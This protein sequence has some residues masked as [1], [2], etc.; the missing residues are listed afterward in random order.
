VLAGLASETPAE[1]QQNDGGG[2]LFIE[3]VPF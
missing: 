1:Q 3:V 2:R